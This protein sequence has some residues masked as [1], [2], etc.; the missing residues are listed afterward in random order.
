MICVRIWRR[1]I[2]WSNVKKWQLDIYRYNLTE[3]TITIQRYW[4]KK[5]LK[6]S[7]AKC[8]PFYSGGYMHTADSQIKRKPSRLINTHTYRW[9]SNF[10]AMS[11]IPTT[12]LTSCHVLCATWL[13]RKL[14]CIMH[15][16]YF[17]DNNT[18]HDLMQLVS[19]KPP[20]GVRSNQNILTCTMSNKYLISAGSGFLGVLW[21][22]SLLYIC[23]G[24][25]F[26]LLLSK[27]ISIASHQS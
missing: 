27:V 24:K 16:T 17:V 21:W 11:F 18:K 12:T 14:M 2:T 8:W 26:K 6:M 1:T 5:H 9:L 7:F 13:L 3:M 10:T 23:R 20:H 4:L 15:F 19:S 25:G 22:V